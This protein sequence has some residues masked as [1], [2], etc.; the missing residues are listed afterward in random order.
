[1]RNTAAALLLLMVL[2]GCTSK[3][4]ITINQVAFTY[5]GNDEQGTATNT[6]PEGQLKSYAELKNGLLDGKFASYAPNGKE[7]ATYYY[8]NGK[9][10]G[11]YKIYYPSGKIY[12]EGYCRNDAKDGLCVR[13]NID[14]TKNAELLYAQ[15][16]MVGLTEYEGTKAVK[17]ELHVTENVGALRQSNFKFSV[18]PTPKEVQYYVIANGDMKIIMGSTYTITRKPGQKFEFAAKGVTENKNVFRLTTAPM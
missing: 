3:Q 10:E 6:Y 17:D 16:D 14:G 4:T 18:T 9:M 5:E 12:E 8:K 11:P 13:Y 1:M 15:K 2:G 7:K